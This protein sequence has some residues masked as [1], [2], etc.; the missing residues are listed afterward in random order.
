MKIDLGKSIFTFSS[1]IAW[2]NAFSLIRYGLA[3]THVMPDSLRFKSWIKANRNVCF[4]PFVWFVRGFIISSSSVQI[5]IFVSTA[6]HDSVFCAP[7][8][9]LSS[10]CNASIDLIECSI[11]TL[12]HLLSS[13]D[14]SYNSG[15][16]FAVE[17]SDEWLAGSDKPCLFVFYEIPTIP[18]MQRTIFFR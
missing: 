4:D 15:P 6:V 5:D 7:A 13:W 18:Y 3:I 14:E 11:K 12:K 10:S 17:T 1:T 9:T 8:F 2:S 16:S